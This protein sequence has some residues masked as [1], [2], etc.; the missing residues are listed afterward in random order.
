MTGN[1]DH[2]RVDECDEAGFVIVNT[3]DEMLCMDHYNKAIDISYLNEP[4]GT[5]Q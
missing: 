1:I 2:C 3:D 4:E 5:D